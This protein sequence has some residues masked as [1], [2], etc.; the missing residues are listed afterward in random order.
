MSG[1]AG[2]GAFVTDSRRGF[3]G[4]NRE[5][6]EASLGQGRLPGGEGTCAAS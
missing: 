3:R 6:G 1:A 2:L 4:M 5:P